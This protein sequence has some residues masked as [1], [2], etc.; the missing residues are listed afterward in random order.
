MPASSPAS[1]WP[2]ARQTAAAK[3]SGRWPPAARAA[4]IR[5]ASPSRLR[6]RPAA[7]PGHRSGAKGGGVIAG[8]LASGRLASGVASAIPRRSASRL[9]CSG[10][11]RGPRRAGWVMAPARLVVTR[12]MVAK[13]G[14]TR[15]GRPQPGRAGRHRLAP[16]RRDLRVGGQGG[17]FLLPKRDPVLRQPVELRIAAAGSRLGSPCPSCPMHAFG[18]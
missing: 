18:S 1:A 3:A 7:A 17:D 5:A 6:A 16:E 15:P 8:R 2:S 14:A 4:A 10:S 12:L 11:G 9:R 13:P